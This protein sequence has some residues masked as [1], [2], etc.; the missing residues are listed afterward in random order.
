MGYS[1]FNSFLSS[2][3]EWAVDFPGHRSSLCIYYTLIPCLLLL[4][5]KLHVTL[6]GTG[7]Q[8]TNE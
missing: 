6:V 3:P 5:F 2:P 1:T 7:L 4:F 8:V